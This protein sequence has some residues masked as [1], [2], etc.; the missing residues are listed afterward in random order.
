MIDIKKYDNITKCLLESFSFDDIEHSD[1]ELEQ[2]DFYKIDSSNDKIKVFYD[3][4]LE[5]IMEKTY[6]EIRSLPLYPMIKFFEA[7]E[8]RVYNIKLIDEFLERVSK[9]ESAILSVGIYGPYKGFHII[10]K[11]YYLIF[12]KYSNQLI[13]HNDVYTKSFFKNESW[14]AI[15]ANAYEIYYS[16]A[17]ELIKLVT[18]SPNWKGESFNPSS[19]KYNVSESFDFDYENDCEN[20]DNSE[21]YF[22][23]DT[24]VDPIDEITTFIN[25]YNINHLTKNDFSIE[26]YNEKVKNLNADADDLEDKEFRFSN[27]LLFKEFCEIC[28]YHGINRLTNI[29]FVID[30]SNES[31]NIKLDDYFLYIDSIYFNTSEDLENIKNSYI[32][33]PECFEDLRFGVDE[34][35][36]Y[37]E[38]FFETIKENY[39]VFVF[40]ISNNVSWLEEDIKNV[41]AYNFPKSLKESFDFDMNDGNDPDTNE[42]FYNADNSHVPDRDVY[43]LFY[44]YLYGRKDKLNKVPDNF[45]N[46]LEKYFKIVNKGNERYFLF[47]DNVYVDEFSLE[48]FTDVDI[49]YFIEFIELCNIIKF[50]HSQDF[51]ICIRPSRPNGVLKFPKTLKRLNMVFN[52]LYSPENAYLEVYL[53]ET[54]VEKSNISYIGNEGV[55]AI[56][57]TDNG[58]IYGN[59][60]FIIE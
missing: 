54:L 32:S 23:A 33:L 26:Q 39:D 24:N 58:K 21:T 27:Q 51:K 4:L 6:N 20:E 40:E 22:T 5:P 9:K 13:N 25:K 52:D 49:Q 7:K 18:A 15:K 45:F 1:I 3:N 55:G 28:K 42:D 16:D 57:P 2:D 10:T 34:E 29:I 46:N 17:I 11:T 19:D 50:P 37:L 35:T 44:E 38:A 59:I 53:N 14:K 8:I 36:V 56:L 60:K 12:T 31:I 43:M 41:I 48:K 47:Q 30:F